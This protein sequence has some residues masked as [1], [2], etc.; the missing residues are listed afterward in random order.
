VDACNP[1]NFIVLPKSGGVFDNQFGWFFEQ[2]G[3]PINNATLL[4]ILDPASANENSMAIQALEQI[5]LQVQFAVAN[6]L[7]CIDVWP[8]DT[9]NS[10][11]AMVVPST[12]QYASVVFPYMKPFLQPYVIYPSNITYLSVNTSFLT[13]LKIYYLL[14]SLTQNAQYLVMDGSESLNIT[15][16]QP[17]A[18][19]FVRLHAWVQAA[20]RITITFNDGQICPSTAVIAG[21]FFNWLGPDG[22]SIACTSQYTDYTFTQQAA[23]A[24]YCTDPQSQICINWQNQVCASLGYITPSPGD[25]YSGCNAGICCVLSTPGPIGY[26]TSMVIGFIGPSSGG[27]GLMLV[28]ELQLLG[29]AATVVPIPAGLAA[30]VVA[31]TGQNTTICNA[32]GACIGP[33]VDELYMAQANIVDKQYFDPQAN[34]IKTAANATYCGNYGGVLATNLDE[35]QEVSLMAPYCQDQKGCWISARNMNVPPFL[36]P[37]FYFDTRC[38]D[39]GCYTLQPALPW[40]YFAVA[41]VNKAQ[42]QTQTPTAQPWNNLFNTEVPQPD[43]FIPTPGSETLNVYSNDNTCLITLYQNSRCSDPSVHGTLQGQTVIPLGLGSWNGY[44]VNIDAYLSATGTGDAYP[45]YLLQPRVP[46]PTPDDFVPYTECFGVCARNIPPDVTIYPPPYYPCGQP[47]TVDP[48]LYCVNELPFFYGSGTGAPLYAQALCAFN[49]CRGPTLVVAPD[50]QYSVVNSDSGIGGILV[51]PWSTLS[52]GVSGGCTAIVQTTIGGE[53]FPLNSGTPFVTA[54]TTP[55]P[56]PENGYFGPQACYDVLQYAIVSIGAVMASPI[57][58]AE[59]NVRASPSPIGTHDDLIMSRDVY[60]EMCTFVDITFVYPFGSAPYTTNVPAQLA[61]NAISLISAY[62]FDPTGGP[63]SLFTYCNNVIAC[64]HCPI[65]QPV[66]YQWFQLIFDPFIN[67]FQQYF[68]PCLN[69]KP[70]QDPNAPPQQSCQPPPQ[71]HVNFIAGDGSFWP[72]W[73]L[74]N[75][76]SSDPLAFTNLSSRITNAGYQNMWDLDQC[77]AISQFTVPPQYFTDVCSVQ[78]NFLCQYDTVKY[79]TL[80]G[81]Q[82]DIC[83]SDSRITGFANPAA[84]CYALFPLADPLQ[85]PYQYSVY[86]ASLDGTLSTFVTENNT[87]SDAVVGYLMSGN[88]SIAWNYPGFPQCLVSQYSTRDIH[89]N[90]PGTQPSLDWVDCNYGALWSYT[91]P[92]TWCDQN[93]GTG[94]CCGVAFVW[95]TN[96]LPLSI[97]D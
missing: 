95:A 53:F 52:I 28:D 68:L 7:A 88:T 79:Q 81:R 77:I 65:T 92:G 71:I 61:H 63:Q 56:S 20:G 72:W 91:C 70:N 82:G 73:P 6:I 74:A 48:W 55:S 90:P 78:R 1:A 64:D 40:D 96:Y 43:G 66:S 19:N 17:Y 84:T 57:V 42:Y 44:F 62:W 4:A 45:V 14:T 94:S 59:I 8:T 2:A 23:Y 50:L 87:F 10:T 35:G 80:A 85:S 67:F 75:L 15:F 30:Q 21:G 34:T 89:P 32:T 37:D 93:T 22:N 27:F 24:T 16:A 83:G 51:Q 25:F 3:L 39:Y 9:Y 36:P 60:P 97:N 26:F 47:N 31:A 41:P 46:S 58:H 18:V 86:Q 13:D 33:C 29:Y 38:Y 54:T 49:E 5:A 69:P 76:E 11:R 12:P